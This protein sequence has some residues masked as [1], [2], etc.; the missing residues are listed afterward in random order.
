[1][2]VE[3]DWLIIERRQAPTITLGALRRGE[4]FRP[5]G[6]AGPFEP[7]RSRDELEDEVE[8]LQELVEQWEPIV[9]KVAKTEFRLAARKTKQAKADRK[10]A[11][12]MREDQRQ[13]KDPLW[14]LATKAKAALKKTKA[15]EKAT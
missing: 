7:W 1:M 2:A 4:P 13:R 14:K 12:R 5:G 3:R 8:R 15:D 6:P 9:T 11:S 10:E